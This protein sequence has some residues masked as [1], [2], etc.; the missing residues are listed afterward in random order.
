MEESDTFLGINNPAISRAQDASAAI[1]RPGK[2]DP[3]TSRNAPT[4]IGAMNMANPENVSSEPQTT[5]TISGVM[6]FIRMGK[7]SRAGT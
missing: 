1:E 4:N 5:A 3:E 6:S 7:V 2:N